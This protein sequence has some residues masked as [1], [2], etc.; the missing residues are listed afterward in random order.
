MIKK[1]FLS[2][3]LAF[4][5]G[6]MLLFKSGELSEGIRKGLYI[7]SYSVIPSLFP[8][9][10]L[11]VFICK[12]SCS[13]FFEMLL[14][15]VTKLLKLPPSCAG[16]LFASA[17]GG[18]P[19]GAKCINDLVCG[20]LLDRKTAAGMLCYCVNAGPPFLISS[21]G[22][23]VFENLKTGVFIFF[24]HILSSAL[25]A[26]FV[27]AF[28]KKRIFLETTA[29]KEHKSTAPALVEAVVSSAESC[30]IMCAFIV[31]FYG[32]L[33]LLQSGAIFSSP[34]GIP[35][36]KALLCGFLEV[37]AGVLSAGET[38]GFSAIIIAGAIASFSGISVMLQVAAAVDKSKIPLFP[39]ILSRFFHAAF[40]AGILRIFLAFS[41]ETASV[42]SVRGTAA[43]AV[44]SA[45]APAAV[46]LLC[47]ASLFL[48]SLVPPKSEKEP[49]FNRIKYKLTVFRHSQTKK[50]VIK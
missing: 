12:S 23:S 8:F 4:S 32:V 2:G 49:L 35:T 6:I 50:S 5:L 47:M 39:F 38:E 30:F 15:P 43:E 41:K 42:F 25:I 33:E 24:A 16:S 45:S 11:S 36:A 20:G 18:Y 14:K 3:I 22:F 48:L 34:S 9:M 19:T 37:T 31:L 17:I 40:T 7:C 46:S 44:L 21:V 1:N 13:D 10:A 28:S 27:S 26:V 29:K